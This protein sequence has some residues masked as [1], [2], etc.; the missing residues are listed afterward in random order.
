MRWR[1]RS[2][3]ELVGDLAG[4]R[5]IH[6]QCHFSADTLAPAQRGADVVGMD[7][8]PAAISAARALTAKLGLD[9][10]ARFVEC[11]LCDA[12]AA[13]GEAGAFDL[14]YTTWG[15]I[16]WLPDLRGW[17]RVVRH[18]L[19]PEGRTSPR[20]PPSP[21]SLALAAADRPVVAASARECSGSPRATRG[22]YPSSVGV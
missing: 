15:A 2:F 1:K 5:V 22:A 13:V 18:F 4:L 12:P 3:P 16:G 11:N 8:S 14:V 7:F 19:K 17:A 9:E 10:R 6:L 20:E 21:Q